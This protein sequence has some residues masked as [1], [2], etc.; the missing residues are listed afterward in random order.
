MD[1]K[2][3]ILKLQTQYQLMNNSVEKQSHSGK[4]PFYLRSIKRVGIT[5]DVF[6]DY[7]TYLKDDEY[8]KNEG[9]R[10]KEGNLVTRMCAGAM[11]DLLFGIN[12]PDFLKNQKSLMNL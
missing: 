4:S 12:S 7:D 6:E 9:Y 11:K 5:K 2:Y 3:E 1:K 8:A 10:S